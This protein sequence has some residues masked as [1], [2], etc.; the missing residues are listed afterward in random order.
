MV[1]N[2]KIALSV[3]SLLGRNLVLAEPIPA[4]GW[5]S[6][7]A[8]GQDLN[9]SSALAIAENMVQFLLPHGYDTLVIDGGWSDA[10]NNDVCHPDHECIDTNG[11]MQPSLIKW[12]SSAGGKGLKPFIDKVHAMGLKVGM[13]TL[14]AT[15]SK[16]ALAAKSPVLGAAAGTTV[17]DIVGKVCSWQ[18]WGYGVDLSKPA[19][20]HW[21][22]SVYE[23]YAHW[24]LDFIKNDCVFADNW[25]DGDGGEALIRGVRAAI[26]KT[27]HETVYSLSPG[28]SAT[29]GQGLN[30]SKVADMYRITGDWHDCES[31]SGR[32]KPNCGNLTSHF[33]QAHEFESLIGS[34][35]F[36][37]LDIL[38][39]YNSLTDPQDEAFRFQ[40]TF[41]CITRSPLM[42]GR[43]LADPSLTSSDLII[44]TN[45]RVLTVNSHSS[46]NRQ[47]SKKGDG[48]YVWAA[49][50]TKVDGGAAAGLYY[51][52]LL[53]H[54]A[55]QKVV[56]V[57]LAELGL[58]ACR[59]VLNLW[60][61]Q[62]E[63]NVLV[64]G[65]LGKQLDAAVGNELYQISGCT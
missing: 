29:V 34:P 63:P 48:Q 47:I 26:D 31:K 32:W 13:H 52:A 65:V 4:R 35:S 1:H 45:E 50:S 17:N 43:D 6:W 58:R 59:K 44:L 14:L 10:Y 64:D 36:P 7:D 40:F 61:G 30:I 8:Y 33:K 25:A 12:P 18:K 3:F 27:G 15:L 28:N 21:L 37:D 57:T 5:N 22:D 42:V 55:S 53:N 11:R 54:G 2:S 24:G 62:E 19:A 9:E 16:A 38:S 46:H 23:Q 56:S 51:V 60:T 49:T 39:P 20:Q 41:W